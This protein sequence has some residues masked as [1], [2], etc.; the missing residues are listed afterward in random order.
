MERK[1]GDLMIDQWLDDHQDEVTQTR[2][3][4]MRW[5]DSNPDLREIKVTE[6][7]RA[8]PE[9]EIFLLIMSLHSMTRDGVLR[10]GY[11]FVMPDGQLGE[12]YKSPTDMPDLEGADF[13]TVFLCDGELE[14]I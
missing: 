7:G 13:Y 4:I 11:R 9:V 2:K 6:F 5:L 14:K 3:L 1:A 12:I 8:L 10:H